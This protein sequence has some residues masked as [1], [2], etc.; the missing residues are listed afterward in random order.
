MRQG[1]GRGL[2]KTYRRPDSAVWWIRYSVDGVEYRE[3]SKSTKHSVATDLLKARLREI[4]D[5]TYIEPGARDVTIAMLLDDLVTNYKMRKLASLPTVTQHRASLL[6]LDPKTK[7][8]GPLGIGA[9][10]AGRLTTARLTRL[11]TDWQDQDVAPATINKQLGTLRAAYYLALE[12]DPPKVKRV[13]TM[14]MLDALNAREGFFEREDFTAVLNALPDDG[15]LRDFV[16]WAYWTGM[17]KGEIAKLTWAAFDRETWTLTLPARSSKTKKPRKLALRGPL[18]TIIERRRAA[19]RTDCPL[20]F[21]RMSDGKPTR[22]YEFRKSWATACKAVGVS[23][24]LF[25]D[26]RRTGVRNLIRAG[27]Q[28][29]VAMKISGHLTEHVFERYNIDTDDDLGEAVEKVAAYVDALPTR[30]TVVPIGAA[31]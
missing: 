1:A 27:V 16:E 28:R 4:D 3:S 10:P 17:R 25:H 19:R 6:D 30:R 11:V 2:G 23:G 29:K 12:S 13:P 20:I 24:R 21:W 14:P 26:L 8:A 31:S 7:K 15:G 9:L 5:G 18:R 22:V